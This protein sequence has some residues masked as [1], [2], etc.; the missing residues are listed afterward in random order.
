MSLPYHMPGLLLQPVFLHRS[1]TF[2]RSRL[3]RPHSG[4]PRKAFKVDS[5][6]DKKL[7]EREEALHPQALTG[8]MTLTFLGFYDKKSALY[9]TVNVL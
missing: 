9:K 5:L 1:L 4:G 6:L 2:M 8:F 7:R 3:C